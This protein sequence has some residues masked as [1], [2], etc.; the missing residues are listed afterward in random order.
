MLS[1]NNRKLNCLAET[2]HS[3][4]KNILMKFTP[5]LSI[6]KRVVYIALGS[7]IVWTGLVFVKMPVLICVLLLGG[8]V[9]GFGLVGFCPLHHAV[10]GGRS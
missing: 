6:W 7:G 8:L 4:F 9:A 2:H 1:E 3:I 5:N 10:K